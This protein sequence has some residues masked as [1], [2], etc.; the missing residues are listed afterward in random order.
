MGMP[1][2]E[3]ELSVWD[4]WTTPNEW[5]EWS[6]QSWWTHD[7]AQPNWS[8]SWE[9]PAAQDW[10]SC[11][12]EAVEIIQSASAS[13]SQPPPRG[14]RDLLAQEKES[15]VDL[16]ATVTTSHFWGNG[17]PRQSDQWQKH[18]SDPWQQYPESD[19]WRQ[20]AQSSWQDEQTWTGDHRQDALGTE[21]DD[22]WST[23]PREPTP[24][25]VACQKPA[26]LVSH[27]WIVKSGPWKVVLNFKFCPSAC[28][29]QD[30]IYFMLLA[31]SVG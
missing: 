17:E 30:F 5:S 29:V 2:W 28:G 27:P 7:A 4:G 10:S 6:Q 24:E 13:E 26:C 19:P 23:W 31:E 18:E 12:K 16:G 3:K 20:P 25:E 14:W 1:L 8:S 22:S 21:R 15:R 9:S 11:V